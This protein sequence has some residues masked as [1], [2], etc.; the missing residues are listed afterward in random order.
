MGKWFD[1]HEFSEYVQKLGIAKSDFRIWLKTFLLKEA[2]RVVSKAKRRQRAVGAVDTGFM[3]NSW[4]IGTQSIQ[5]KSMNDNYHVTFDKANSDVASIKVIGN[6]LQVEIWN[7]A[8]YASFIEFGQR[9]Y[10][11]KYLLTIAISEVQKA[12]PARFDK[13]FKLWLKSKG[14][15]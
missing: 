1:Y 15:V 11:G 9:S 13:D 5:L 3:I 4:G 8:E 12:L 6:V 14:V 10:S 2:Q 7:A